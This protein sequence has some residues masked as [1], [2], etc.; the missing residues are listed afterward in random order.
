MAENIDAERAAF[1]AWAKDEKA[2]FWAANIERHKDGY[3][4]VATDMAW[5]AWQAARR[6][7][8]ASIGEDELPE[9]GDAVQSVI[10]CA[11]RVHAKFGA[12]SD[13]SEW[14]DLGDALA[15]LGKL[16]NSAPQA[17]Q[18]VSIEDIM[19]LADNY[20][21]GKYTE[22]YYGAIRA[23]LERAVTQLARQCQGEPVAWAAFA[24]NGNIR[25]W[26]SAPE[27]VRKLA[28][29]VG[30]ELTPLYAAPPLSSEQRADKGEG[31]CGS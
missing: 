29:S 24:D 17:A 11:R 2:P 13:W 22:G 15:D 8:S 16:G 18:G 14:R 3:V 20:A 12:D 28:D 4:R 21:D 6:T 31:A 27:N 19:R 10:A 1:E 26:T 30:M 5:A 23:Q 7:P 9:R 25:I